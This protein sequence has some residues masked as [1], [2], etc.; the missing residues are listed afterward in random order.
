MSS[1][2]LT[3]GVEGSDPWQVHRIVP[4]LAAVALGCVAGCEGDPPPRQAKPLEP[5]RAFAYEESRNGLQSL[6]KD[7]LGAVAAE[8]RAQARHLAKTLALQT[9]REWFDTTFGEEL[10]G[11]AYEEFDALM[12]KPDSAGAGEQGGDQKAAKSGSQV[13]AI[14]HL[15]EQL[16][17]D[18]QTRFVVE[19]F[20][21]AKDDAATGYQAAA[22]SK[23]A[24]ATPLYSVRA[25]DRDREKVFHIW[26]FVYQKGWFRWVGKMRVLAADEDGGPPAVEEGKP[27]VLEYRQRDAEAVLEAAEK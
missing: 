14:V 3:A 4:I 24:E 11:E 27:D 6:F 2:G 17:K 7:M 23:M 15:V 16:H 8:D 9:P 19:R 5:I 10:G 1:V 21:E 22:L 20:T 26:S 25:I 13:A 12:S 18:D